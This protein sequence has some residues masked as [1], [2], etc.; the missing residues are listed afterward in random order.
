MPRG[1]TLD[2]TFA[3][4]AGPVRRGVAELRRV[5]RLRGLVEEERREGDAFASMIGLGRGDQLATLRA[6][7]AAAAR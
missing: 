2:D 6:A 3:A 7:A 1:P 5:L 4:L